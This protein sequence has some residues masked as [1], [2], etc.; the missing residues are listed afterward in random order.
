MQIQAINNQQ[1]SY[2]FT[3]TAKKAYQPAFTGRIINGNY[4]TNEIISLAK[5]YRLSPTWKDELR[6][7]KETIGDAVRTWHYDVPWGD[8]GEY[9][10]INRLLA[11]LFS[12]GVS[13]IFMD[14]ASAI[15]AAVNNNR[16]EN[17]IN[18]IAKCID[19]INKSNQ[20]FVR[21][22]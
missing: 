17:K 22:L 13:E 14:T 8:S 7:G 19:D 2:Q 11:G 10:G 12:F 6:K 1:T 3:K 20:L 9:V 4:Y 21:S 5:E 18:E 15:S 16:I